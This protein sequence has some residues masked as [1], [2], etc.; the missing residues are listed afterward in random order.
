MNVDNV[1]ESTR[2]AFGSPLLYDDEG[3]GNGSAGEISKCS[4]CE[5][6]LNTIFDSNGRSIE[7][8]SDSLLKCHNGL[9]MESTVDYIKNTDDRIT[10]ASSEYIKTIDLEETVDYVN[11]EYSEKISLLSSK[12][13]LPAQYASTTK[14]SS[15]ST[16]HVNQN[17]EDSMPYVQKSK[18][19]QN[20]KM[21][22]SSTSHFT[23]K[24]TDEP[25]ENVLMEQVEVDSPFSKNKSTEV[26]QLRL[27][28]LSLDLSNEE[29]MRKN[30]LVSSDSEKPMSA[31]LLE[32]SM[33]PNTSTEVFSG[34]LKWTNNLHGNC[35]NVEQS[36]KDLKDLSNFEVPPHNKDSKERVLINMG[37]ECIDRVTNIDVPTCNMSTEDSERVGQSLNNIGPV[38]EVQDSNKNN[39]CSTPGTEEAIIPVLKIE[40]SDIET[41]NLKGVLVA[42][43]GSGKSSGETQ[44]LS[45]ESKDF[46]N[47]LTGRTCE[48]T[49][50]IASPCSETDVKAYTS[51]PVP[52]SKNMTFSVP[53]LE[54]IGQIEKTKNPNSGK[55]V[56]LCNGLD[57][58]KTCPGNV[59][60]RQANRKPAMV[61]SV[62]KGKKNE[63]VNFPKPN[64][65]NVRAK[66][67]SRPALNARDCPSSASK[68]SPRSPQSHSSVSSP[69]ASPRTSA[70]TIKTLKKKPVPDQDLRAE[71]AIAKSQKQ[72]INKLLFPGQPAHAP[73]HTKYALGKVPRAAV[74][75][76][77]QDD[78]E[79]AS[80]SNSTRSSGSAAVVTCTARLT[81]QKGEKAKTISKTAAVNGVHMGPDKTEQNGLI[82]APYE[83]NEFQNEDGTS[84]DIFGNVSPFSTRITTPSKNLHKELLSCLKSTTAQVTTAKA[85][86]HSTELRRGSLTRTVVRVSSPPRGNQQPSGAGGLSSPKGKSSIVKA[87]AV[88]GTRSLPRTRVPCKAPTLQRT[89]SVSSVCS[90]Q[91][92]HSTLS[93]RSTTGTSSIRTD[94]VPAKC[95][96][97]NG[98]AGTHAA[99]VTFPRVRSQSL[100]VTQTVGTKKS[101]ILQQGV[102][103]SSGSSGLLKRTDAKGINGGTLHG[104]KS[105][106][107]VDKGKQKPSPRGPVTQVQTPPVQTQALELAQ[108]KTICEEQSGIIQQLK[109]LLSSRNQR[110]EALTVVIQHVIKQRE[111]TVKKRKELSQELQN[112]RGDLVSASGT[113][114]KL[115]KEKNDLLT[116][117]E[118]IL[119]KVK[120]EHFAE[121]SDLEEKLKQFYT[122]ECEKLQTIFIEEAEKYK[123]E[124]QEKVDDLNSTHE[125]Y[126]HAAE[127]SH[128]EEIKNIKEE[129]EK[130]LTELK[131]SQEREN[132][133][134]EDSFKEKQAELEKKIEELRQENESL[135]EKLKAEEEQRKLSK[136]KTALKNPQV[137]YLEQELESLKAV[138]EI[139]NEKLH[140]QD[141]KLMQIEKL[142]ETNTILVEKLNKCQQEN[143]DLKARMAN[144]I[145]ISRQLST[146]Q[147]VLQRSLEKESKANKR[148]SM[149]NEELLW[150]LHNGDL[151]SP[152][153]LS[154]S[155]PGI[156]F[157]PRNSGTFTSPTVSPR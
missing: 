28:S 146:E 94:E 79:R 103:K 13:I 122:G 145:A 47:N 12:I 98:A 21:D 130:S 149:E 50:L 34:S 107:V 119:Q 33:L 31:S 35:P 91:S 97:Q 59:A 62:L 53:M 137:M 37:D 111:E 88:I 157:H 100:K 9:E 78:I 44:S 139:K 18:E 142:V 56:N 154:P 67:L 116:A 45:T 99:K 60:A 129:Y 133:A 19:A 83:K 40:G 65:K 57:T 5:Q 77:T 7:D 92:D 101:P 73:T 121:L 136:E 70:S 96:K 16:K 86:L 3:N 55:D 39:L 54:D 112:L 24:Q 82:D 71:A 110:F 74:L 68:P 132:K 102:T 144:H 147:E 120:D 118:G 64:F 87:S 36:S 113:C 115:E 123:F 109:N 128:A 76:Q 104:L 14:S 25:C 51:T 29:F 58:V 49:F 126:R 6:N 108:C 117:Y 66:V 114:E 156:P 124:L 81:E 46:L 90:T 106:A 138:L 26:P 20:K 1:A 125:A 105:S 84:G 143:E 135:K 127:T 131:D 134:L 85:R 72:P 75:K 42:D 48:D 10:A 8:C 150:K 30:S 155:S 140:Q 23:I 38:V 63:L 17:V 69:V 41:K 95:V 89:P 141:K 151:C 11:K 93:T 27:F 52:E 2:N 80:S 15:S 43:T 22:S 152:K 61:P 32:S 4:K 153:K 148:L